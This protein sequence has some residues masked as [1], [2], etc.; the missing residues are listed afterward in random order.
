MQPKQFLVALALALAATHADA[1]TLISGG[2]SDAWG[3]YDYF[4]AGYTIWGKTF[5]NPDAT[6]PGVAGD[7]L[8]VEQSLTAWARVMGT[9]RNL[10]E[11][12]GDGYHKVNSTSADYNTA[13]HTW[14][15]DFTG[16]WIKY[17]LWD[18]DWNPEDGMILME[19]YLDWTFYSAEKRFYVV[20]KVKASVKGTVGYYM[21]GNGTSTNFIGGRFTPYARVYARLTASIDGFVA[22]AGA[23]GTIELIEGSAP[24]YN[25]VKLDGTCYTSEQHIT[26]T[27]SE[28]DGEAGVFYRYL[29]SSPKEQTIWSWNGYEQSFPVYDNEVA[30]CL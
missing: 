14:L 26:A 4:Q 21:V 22:E 27:L 30:G 6:Y 11:V 23:Y 18:D 16:G 24:I 20:V 12:K 9:K 5:H 3:P 25:N 19:D 1:N 29:W 2:K 15:P 10:V 8:A 7:S 28:L 13:V 17:R